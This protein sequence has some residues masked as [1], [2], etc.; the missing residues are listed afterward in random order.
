VANLPRMAE[1]TRQLRRQVQ[2]FRRL[3][4]D[5][6]GGRSTELLLLSRLDQVKAALRP[7]S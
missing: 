1:D 4:P 7:L 3:V 6:S 2:N 5:A